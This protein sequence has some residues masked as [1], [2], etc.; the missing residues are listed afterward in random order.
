MK[1]T[2]PLFLSLTRDVQRS[3]I[4]ALIFAANPDELLT[5]KNIFSIVLSDTELPIIKQNKNKDNKYE[6]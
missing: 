1:A 3:I 6:N 5:E 2:L 4:E